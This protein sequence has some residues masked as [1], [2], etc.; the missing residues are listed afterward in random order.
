MGTRAAPICPEP[1]VHQAGPHPSHVSSHH[2]SPQ[3]PSSVPL[4]RYWPHLTDENTKGLRDSKLGGWLQGQPPSETERWQLWAANR[5]TRGRGMM[6][7]CAN[8]ETSTEKG[9]GTCPR[10][11]EG[12]G[13][14]TSEPVLLEDFQ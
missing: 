1:P 6:T 2:F 12:T 10:D 5:P 11:T 14:P 3:H 4:S 9:V 13:I 8:G 7:H